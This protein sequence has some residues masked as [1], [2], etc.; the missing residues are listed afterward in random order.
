MHL[1]WLFGISEPSTVPVVVML[2]K[3][4][5]LPSFPLSTRRFHPKN[6]H[7]L[8]PHGPRTVVHAVPRQKPAVLFSIKTDVL[9]YEIVDN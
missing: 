2:V 1:R 5:S 4:T 7:V 8:L 9:H 6:K 3:L